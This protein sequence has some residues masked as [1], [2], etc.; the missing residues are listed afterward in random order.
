MAVIERGC[1]N[2]L[3]PQIY[4][5]GLHNKVAPAINNAIN[6]QSTLCDPVTLTINLLTSK[7]ILGLPV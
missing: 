3:P 4:V 7:Y 2:I 5:Y 6:N 1:S